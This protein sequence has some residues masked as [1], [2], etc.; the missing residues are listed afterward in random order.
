MSGHILA[1]ILR[2][3][4]WTAMAAAIWKGDTA[5]RVAGA[6]FL[7]LDISAILINPRVGDVSSETIT[8]ALDFA[9]A[10]IFLLLAVRYANLWIGAAM[11]FQAAQFS[12]HAYYLVMELPHDRM[13]AWINNLDDAGILICIVTGTVLAIRRRMVVARETAQLEAIRKQRSSAAP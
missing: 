10:V 7:I 9:C 4:A 8:L 1:E 2:A 5:V 11:I 3:I 12:L 6:S 13:H